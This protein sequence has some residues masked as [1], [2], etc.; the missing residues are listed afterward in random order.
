MMGQVVHL[1]GDYREAAPGLADVGGFDGDAE[2]KQVGLLG[3]A[4]DHFEDLTDVYRVAAEGLDVDI[5]G[6]D[7]LEKF[8][9]RADGLLNHLLAVF[10]PVVGVGRMV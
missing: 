5:G 9:R 3:D 1:V 4:F 7:P 10:G 6:A 2:G 8:V